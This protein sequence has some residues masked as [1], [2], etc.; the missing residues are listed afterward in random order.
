MQTIEEQVLSMQ[1]LPRLC[2]QD[3]KS[4]KTLSRVEAGSNTFTVALRVVGD[5]EK[6]SL[7]SGTVK[8]VAS[9]TGLRPENDC[10]GEVQQ[11]L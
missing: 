4:R 11:Q 5:D 8:L 9:T 3:L 6:G 2:G 1:Y 7:E 10:S